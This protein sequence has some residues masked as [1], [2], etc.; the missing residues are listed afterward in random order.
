MLGGRTMDKVTDTEITTDMID[1]MFNDYLSTFCLDNKIDDEYDIYPSMWNAAL[2]YIYNNIFKPNP[3]ILR[4]KGTINGAYNLVAV[5]DVLDIYI[6]KCFVH[7]QEISLAGFCLFTGITRDVIYNWGKSKTR[8]VIYKDL[9]GNV[10]TNVQVSKLK[11]G[12]YIEELSTLAKDIFEKIKDNSE[13]SLVSLLKDKRYNPMKILPIL[14]RRFLWN[15]PGVSHENA[16][17]TELTADDIRSKLCQTSQQ[18]SLDETTENIN[19]LDT[20]QNG[21]FT[22]VADN[23]N[24]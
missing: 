5:N 17:K 6:Y 16:S 12:E 20:I 19:N 7:N 2:K 9:K 13:E 15:L 3:N 4:P 11:E 24:T 22:G 14:N 8:C 1:A 10:L 23:S 21:L 18:L